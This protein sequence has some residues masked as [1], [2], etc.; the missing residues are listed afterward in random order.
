MP[1]TINHNII[2]NNFELMLNNGVASGIVEFIA[3]WAIPSQVQYLFVDIFDLPTNI[4]DFLCELAEKAGYKEI[5][6]ILK[7]ILFGATV[8]DEMAV[9][10]NVII[11]NFLVGSAVYQT[12][13]VFDA[14]GNFKYQEHSIS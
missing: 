3:G 13:T 4:T 12:K 2:D 7:L 9:T 14:N 6:I 1:V 11:I 8:D 5:N 10:D